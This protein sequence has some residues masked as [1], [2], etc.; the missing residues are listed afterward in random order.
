MLLSAKIVNQ[1]KFFPS[2]QIVLGY[3]ISIIRKE[4]KTVSSVTLTKLIF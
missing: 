1:M 2:N 3:L 4:T